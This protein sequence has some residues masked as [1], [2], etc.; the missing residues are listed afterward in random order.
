VFPARR[1]QAR[2]LAGLAA[3]LGVLLGPLACAFTDP[4]TDPFIER[5]PVTDQRVYSF[6]PGIL[7]KV[8]VMPFYPD[9]V[10][11]AEREQRSVT[12]ADSA[13]LV[14]RFATEALL[15]QGISAVAPSDLANAFDAQGFPA[16]RLDPISAG[17]LAARE[18]G[19]TAVLLGKVTRY[20][21]R[22]S[23][24]K[25]SSVAFEMTLYTAPEGRKAWV[26]VFDETQRPLSENL[27]NAR[28]Y[29]GGGSRWL[30]A[31]E[32]ARWGAESAIE[33]LPAR[34]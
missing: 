28:R 29:P 7:D 30:T 3:L 25:P 31:A 26:S 32:L 5:D 18:F 2:S 14:A 8:A 22:A 34:R 24:S 23:A 10:Q 13:D 15:S 6:P 12:P 17:E 16:P 1:S 20:R 19:A 11:S 9:F 4:L 33:A 21:E 27:V